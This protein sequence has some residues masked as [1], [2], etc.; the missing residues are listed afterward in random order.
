MLL[1]EK[2]KSI[3]HKGQ[4]FRPRQIFVQYFPLK[5]QNQR[6]IQKEYLPKGICS[7]AVASIKISK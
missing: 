6:R 5:H 2:H 1:L 7:V 3:I 4:T